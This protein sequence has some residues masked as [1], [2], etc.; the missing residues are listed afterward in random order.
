MSAIETSGLLNL[1]MQTLCVVCRHHHTNLVIMMLSAFVPRTGT[2]TGTGTG[3]TVHCTMA[4]NAH[5]TST[6]SGVAARIG[7]GR[8]VFGAG[9]VL[10]LGTWNLETHRQTVSASCATTTRLQCITTHPTQRI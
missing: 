1:L 2:G 5:N 4:Q 10:E 6:G 7:D 9:F 3:T 8:G